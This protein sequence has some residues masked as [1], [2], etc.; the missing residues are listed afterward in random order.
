M[1]SDNLPITKFGIL[2]AVIYWLIATIRS[3]ILI[4]DSG[5]LTNIFNPGGWDLV[6]RIFT[7]VGILGIT[8][9]IQRFVRNLKTEKHIVEHELAGSQYLID[10]AN[11]PIIELDEQYRIKKINK[12]TAI[13]TGYKSDD[14]LM[15]DAVSALFYPDD[16]EHAKKLLDQTTKQ[17]ITEN[18]IKL[19][20]KRIQEC[21]VNLQV[22]IEQSEGSVNKVLLFL[23]DVT[24]LFTELK[25]ISRKTTEIVDF[26]KKYHQPLALVDSDKV[27]F[28]N[29]AMAQL[30][31]Q[32]LVETST[33]TLMEFIQ[34][35]VHNADEI[36]QAFDK[37]LTEKQT[38]T[39]ESNLISDSGDLKKQI[40]IDFSPYN[41]DGK[42]HVLIQVDDI[43]KQKDAENKNIELE[44]QLEQLTKKQ[45]D[46][47]QEYEHQKEYFR[48][49]NS[50]LLDKY[51][52]EQ[53]KNNALSVE[54]ENIKSKLS[55]LEEELNQSQQRKTEQDL[56]IESLKQNEEEIATQLNH[57]Q[58]QLAEIT[59]PVITLDKEGQILDINNTARS[60]LNL[61]INEPLKSY[62]STTEQ[63]MKFTELLEQITAGEA[64]VAA[65]L[66]FGTQSNQVVFYCHATQHDDDQVL[67]Y[68]YDVSQFHQA[69]QELAL[70]LE[71]NRFEL[72]DVLNEIEIERERMNAVLGGI[73]DGIVITDM[74]NRVTKMNPAA[75]DLLG[76]RLSQAHERPVHFVIRNHEI[77]EHIQ[78]TVHNKLFDHDFI[79]EIKPPLAEQAQSFHFRTTV[80]QD[81]NLHEQG[82]IIQLRRDET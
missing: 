31:G 50:Q 60:Q 69:Q 16:H 36:I 33:N 59:L 32:E 23:E 24:G 66:E 67:L 72:E 74:Y 38:Y 30:T 39:V 1:Q 20:V 49:E 13:L 42:D 75:E 25:L 8:F 62:L 78:K 14:L 29:K 65:E 44:Q 2:F 7:V 71:N 15:K 28:S 56:L 17:K 63:Q 81:R 45:Q 22:S 73:N 41:Y 51:M 54:L 35:H 10:V 21:Y 34:S 3:T 76:I 61:D 53:R 64:A 70:S 55:E 77:I 80:I 5:F 40:R 58:K 9:I 43:S 47:E 68:G 4:E 46:L 12:A 6:L 52:E 57:L 11:C 37:T 82:V 79:L 27:Y 48:T 26:L 19:R 18:P